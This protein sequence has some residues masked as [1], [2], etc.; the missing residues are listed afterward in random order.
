MGPFTSSI[1]F[2]FF[3]FSLMFLITVWGLFD[4]VTLEI[5]LEH[6]AEIKWMPLVDWMPLNTLINLWYIFIG[7]YWCAYTETAFCHGILKHRDTQLFYS[8]NLMASLYGC[9]QMARI[10]TQQ[11]AWS[12]LDQWCTLPFFSMVIVWGLFYRYGWSTG[13]CL[14][15]MSI[16][17]GSYALTLFTPIGFEICLGF[18]ILGA[19]CGGLLA[20][21][22]HPTKESL[23]YFTG[24]L[25]MCAG[26]VFLKLLD[27]ILP[28]IS[29]IFQ[30]VSGHFLS[31][32]CDA[33]QI[34]FVNMFFFDTALQKSVDVSIED[35]RKWLGTDDEKNLK[36]EVFG[37]ETLHDISKNY[38][39]KRM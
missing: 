20:Y 30:Y 28:S 27:L 37:R 6:Y 2:V 33:G 24:G 1:I 7:L 15:L 16:S 13:R 22:K 29:F 31:K 23:S 11:V 32:I 36:K 18:H 14:G 8:F 19:L 4:N 34:Y 35:K 25:I 9:V 21:W 3:T 5:G 38:K 10:V 26:F 12:V 39:S 17:I